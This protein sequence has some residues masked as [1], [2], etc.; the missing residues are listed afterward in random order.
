MGAKLGRVLMIN[1]RA[2]D[3]G[4]QNSASNTAFIE[5]TPPV[6]VATDKFVPGAI[7]VQVTVYATFELE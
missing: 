3:G 1:E 7:K 4:W 6:D 5:S 2:K